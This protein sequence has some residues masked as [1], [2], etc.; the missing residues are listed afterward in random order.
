MLFEFSD[1]A[2]DLQEWL[3]VFMDKH[4]YPYE[5]EFFRQLDAGDR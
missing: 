5:P 1:Q 2:S 4:I 3:Q